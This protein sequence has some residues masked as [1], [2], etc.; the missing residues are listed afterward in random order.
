MNSNKIYISNIL[1]VKALWL[2]VM[3]ASF[4]LYGMTQKIYPSEYYKLPQT[5]REQAKVIFIAKFSTGR[6]RNTIT[7][8][9]VSIWYPEARLEIIKDY[10]GKLKHN[11]VRAEPANAFQTNGEELE[12]GPSYLFL[13]KPSSENMNILQGEY[14]DRL[15]LKPAQEVLAVVKLSN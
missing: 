8:N 9:G 6:G 11:M 1:Q 15:T 4:P 13:L 7:N 3:L 2:C 14:A 12:F 5:F 10:S